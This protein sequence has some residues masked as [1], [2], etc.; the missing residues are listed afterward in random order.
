MRY[1][2][3]LKTKIKKVKDISLRQFAIHPKFLLLPAIKKI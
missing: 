2:E 1:F 3:P